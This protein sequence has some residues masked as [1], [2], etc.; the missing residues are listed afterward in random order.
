VATLDGRSPPRRLVEREGLQALFGADGDIIFASRK[1]G[2]NSIYRIREDGTNARA[3][4]EASTVERVSPDG[5]WVTSWE[6]PNSVKIQPI[7]GGPA[8]LICESCVEPPTFE[9]GP[10][11][12]V[13]SWSA[14]GKIFYL[15]F[16]KSV[17]A[18]PLRPG[19]VMP[20]IPSTGFHNVDEVA[21]LPGARRIAEVGATPGPT[22]ATYAFTK[23]ATQR[24]IYR[25]PVP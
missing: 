8:R 17:Y 6:A 7:D 23:I 4:A 1:D 18:I 16:D 13:V 14:D 12:P 24:N 2:K 9:S 11:A 25:V 19:E 21:A 10:P 15:Q 3:I 20:P 5:R 22:P